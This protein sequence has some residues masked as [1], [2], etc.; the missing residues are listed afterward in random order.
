M[1]IIK[2][3][4]K[5]VLNLETCLIPT[6]G[7]LHDGHIQLINEGKILK[8]PLIV[9]IFVNPIQFNDEDDFAKYPKTIEKD[10]EILNK[11]QVD[12][13][14]IPNSEYI[15]PSNGFES[16]DSSELGRKYEGK[17]RPGHFDGVLTVVNRLFE[18]IEPK[19]AIFGKKDAQQLFLIKKLILDKKYPIQIIEC[20][21]VR[22][23]NGLALSSRNMLLSKK[24]ENI[25]TS[26]KKILNETKKNFLIS[27]D[28][29]NSLMEVRNKFFTKNLK[30]DYLEILDY[31]TFSKPTKIS[32]SYVIVI[33]AYV[34]GVRLIDNLDFQLEETV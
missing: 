15:Y 34:E 10:I 9:S 23:N 25:A 1:K 32:K 21:T 19:A 26:I 6:M 3:I 12:Y 20:K 31:Q 24:G 2:E 33:A 7:A 13:L 16:I 22:D 17:S 27:K 18:L 28:I 29:E 5:D 8:L 30:I 14:F 4:D 11:L